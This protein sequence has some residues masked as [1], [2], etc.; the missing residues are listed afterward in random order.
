MTTIRQP[1]DQPPATLAGGGP[2]GAARRAFLA[3]RP[4]FFTASVLPVLVGTAFAA[5]RLHAFSG[6]WFALALAATVLAHAA[7][8]VYNDVGD[9]ANGT[10][11]ANTERIYP[12]T[13]GSR[14][15]QAGLMSREAMR[16]LAYLLGAGAVAFGVALA[17]LRGP[18]VVVLGIAGLALGWLYSL[19]GAA[20]SGRGIGELAVA[21]GLGALPVIG[22]SWL[23]AGSVDLGVVLVSL[24]VSA[25]VAAILLINE[26][27]DREADGAAGKRTLVVRFGVPG[28]RVIYGVLTLVALGGSVAAVATGAL[29]RPYLV[30]AALLA[31]AGFRAASGIAVGPAARAGL[32]RSIELTLAIH[33]LG[34]LALFG[35]LLASRA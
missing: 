22:S 14:F 33:A 13:G 15:I 3:T 5:A 35:A 6:T 30:A 10:D 19:P 24:P 16:R 21:V 8:N 29:P 31:L 1:L 25:W 11:P 12:Y 27:P 7:T 32:K 26:V 34:S 4:P 20:L 17:L 2:L 18:G 9:D 28:T 23:Q